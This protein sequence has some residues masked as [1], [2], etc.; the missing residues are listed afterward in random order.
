MNNLLDYKYIIL[1]YIL[2]F[3]KLNNYLYFGIYYVVWTIN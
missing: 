1:K 3:Y 2:P